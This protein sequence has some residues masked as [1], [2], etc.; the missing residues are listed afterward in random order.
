[1]EAVEHLLARPDLA[2]SFHTK[3]F[4]VYNTNGD[5]VVSDYFSANKAKRVQVC[6]HMSH[7]CRYAARCP[8]VLSNLRPDQELLPEGVMQVP[9]ICASDETQVTNMCGD[10][11][12]YPVYLTLGNFT[13]AA[14][15]KI[16]NGPHLLLA[17]LPV[18]KGPK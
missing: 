12:A 17:Y 11:T 4:Q 14:R 6:P 16:N 15:L 9:L 1:M 10:K 5:R 13:N 3:P 18:I 2:D 8:D 7:V